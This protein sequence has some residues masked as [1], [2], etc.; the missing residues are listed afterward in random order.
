MTTADKFTV[1]TSADWVNPS[2][3]GRWTYE[4]YLSLPEDGNHYEIVNGVLYMAPSPTGEHQDAVGRIYHYLLVNLEFAGLG[5][6]RFA[7]FDVR[8]SP[9]H[10]FQPDVLVVLNTHRDRIQR[11]FILGAP[12]LVVEIASPSTANIDRREKL[13]AY[14]RSGVPE[15][16][17]VDADAH[18]VEVLMLE[19]GTYRSLGVFE[20]EDTLP[21]KI[22]PNFPV[23]VHQFFAY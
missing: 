9:K 7:P 3:Q 16:W 4:D 8:L 19:A 20:D 21:T 5:K 1:A 12:D 6:V 14:A 2:K 23:Q 17:L 13:D 18:T 11:R 10:V 15:Y 22:V